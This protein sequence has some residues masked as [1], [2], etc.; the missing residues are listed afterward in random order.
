LPKE[1]VDFLTVVLNGV[2]LA[3]LY[4]VV[5]SGFTLIF[6]L[7]RTTNMAHGAMY[8]LGAYAGVSAVQI[9]GDWLIGLPF[10]V[11]AVL[12]ATAAVIAI[13]FF[14]RGAALAVAPT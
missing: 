8:V 11:C 7:M 14:R 12:Q 9:S 1:L 4:F 5:A 13:R 10:F 3:A 6:G 2:T